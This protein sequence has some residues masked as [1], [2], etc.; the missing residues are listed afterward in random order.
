[1][2]LKCQHEKISFESRVKPDYLNIFHSTLLLF[3]INATII[4]H[5]IFCNLS[6]RDALAKQIYN[7]LFAWLIGKVNSV[8]FRG[9]LPLSIA[10]LDIFGFEVVT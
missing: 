8:I 3:A 9:K 4:I 10:V 2:T 6:C 7:H 5:L 1:M